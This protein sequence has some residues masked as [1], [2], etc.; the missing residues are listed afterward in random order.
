[1]PES[2]PDPGFYTIGG[3][4]QAGSGVYIRREAD[5][6]LL[7]RCRAG[8]FAYVLTPRQLGKSS[9]M[10]G[11]AEQLA[12]DD[13][14]SAKISLEPIGRQVTADQW[15]LGLRV[16]LGDGLNFH[17]DVVQCWRRHDECGVVQR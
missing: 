15:Y 6:E 3:T 1:M 16:A 13:I 12:L 14:R 9:L 7:A 11:T 2:M 17:I 8:E 5:D 4:V 10:E